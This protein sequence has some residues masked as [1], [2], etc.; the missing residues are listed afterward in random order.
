MAARLIFLPRAA[1]QL[2]GTVFHPA[3]SERFLD[4]YSVRN[5]EHDFT[6]DLLLG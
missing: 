2:S 4:L 6:G 1:E 3:G 5:R